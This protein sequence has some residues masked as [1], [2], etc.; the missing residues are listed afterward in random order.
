MRTDGHKDRH[1]TKLRV[2]SRNFANMPNKN[3]MRGQ[4]HRTTNSE[5]DLY[6]KLGLSL[7]A[8]P[9]QECESAYSEYRIHCLVNLKYGSKISIQ[10]Q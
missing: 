2:A 10:L 8:G 6:L 3:K 9:S 1:M 4:N 5:N 7:R